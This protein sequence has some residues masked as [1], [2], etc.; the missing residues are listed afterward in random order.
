MHGQNHDCAQQDE[1]RVG[2]LFELIHL[3]EAIVGLMKN[4]CTILN[5][6][7]V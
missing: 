2:A 6:Q 4:E 7:L 1:K 5:Q 3:I